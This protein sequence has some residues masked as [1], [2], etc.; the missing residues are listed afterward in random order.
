MSWFIQ[1]ALAGKVFVGS[2]TAAGVDLPA[3]NGTAQTFGIWNPAGSGVMAVLGKLTLGIVDATTPVLSGLCLSY[4]PN[5]GSAIGAAGAPLTAFTQTAAINAI[6]GYGETSKVRFT[7]AATSIAA[8]IHSSVGLS[9]ESTTAG[10][11]LV[12]PWVDFSG[13]V[14]IPPNVAVFLTGTA[15]QTQNLMPTITWAE[16]PYVGVL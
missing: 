13:S 3:S 4:V 12:G 14:I 1:Q 8:T 5:A 15:A 7:L 6:I 16:V 10:N 9:H 2:A 11:G